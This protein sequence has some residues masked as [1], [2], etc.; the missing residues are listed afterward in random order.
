VVQKVS[1]VQHLVVMPQCAEETQP[2]EL[3]NFVKKL[4]SASVKDVFVS[5]PF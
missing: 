5:F 2:E 3:E 1:F 4:V